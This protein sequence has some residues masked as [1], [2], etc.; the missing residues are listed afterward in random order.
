MNFTGPQIQSPYSASKISADLFLES[1]VKS[2]NLPAVILR[3]FNT[4]GP[5]QSEKAVMPSIIRQIFD[6]R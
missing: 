6:N 5:R 3:P 1:Y 2:F 4:Y